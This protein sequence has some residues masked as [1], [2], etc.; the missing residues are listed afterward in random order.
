MIEKL[1]NKEWK[2]QNINSIFSNTQRGKRFKLVDHKPGKIPYI[3]STGFNNGVDDFC[4]DNIKAR[5]FSN[6]ITIANSG[7]VGKCFYHPYSFIASDHVTSLVNS[8]GKEINLFLSACLEKNRDNFNF[9][10]EI[11]NLRLNALKIMLPYKNSSVLDEDFMCDYIK[12]IEKNLLNR[13][14]DF[15]KK[16]IKSLEPY[17]EIPPLASKTWKEF[18]LEELFEVT[19]SVTTH[20]SILKENGDIPRVTCSGSTNGIEGFYK[21]EP[22]EEKNVITIDSATTGCISYQ[23]FDFIATDHVEK[24]ISK[25]DGFNKE[26]GLFIK[27]IIDKA[28]LN[29]YSY[30]YKFS[31]KRIQRQTIKLPI[32]NKGNPDYEYMEQYTKNIMLK[33]YKQYLNYLNK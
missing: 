28:I 7:S 25:Y 16:E 27:N 6:C 13:Y 24:L 3:S 1:E 26:I 23:G 15:I 33:K 5:K 11:N 29:K 17:V 12:E 2:A 21:N 20:P 18:K 8:K 19:G 22:T 30:G 32:T 4:E 10:R 9:N 14:L 31:Q